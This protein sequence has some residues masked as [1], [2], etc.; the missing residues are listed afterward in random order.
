MK[1]L[2]FAAGLVTVA[3]VAKAELPL[4]SGSAW[5]AVQWHPNQVNGLYVDASSIALRNDGRVTYWERRTETAPGSSVAAVEYQRVGTCGGDSTWILASRLYDKAGK[6][7][8][9]QSEAPKVAVSFS[10][11]PDEQVVLGVA[12]SLLKARHV[13]G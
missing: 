5:K 3:M 12:C 7:V 10:R 4:D 8:A 9:S 1:K 11:E 13:A 2:I 6:Q